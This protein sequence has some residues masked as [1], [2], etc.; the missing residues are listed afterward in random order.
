MSDQE[1]IAF[2]KSIA[3]EPED[4]ASRLVFADFLD[5]QDEE[6]Y[7]E[8]AAFIRAD[9]ELSQIDEA[10]VR[11]PEMLARVRR[12]GMFTSRHRIPWLSSVPNAWVSFHRGL[13]SGVMLSPEDHLKHEREDW[14]RLPIEQVHWVETESPNQWNRD[15]GE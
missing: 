2:Q 15:L 3:S 9:I 6:G 5:E 1:L 12:A 7:S 11:Y 10:D 8:M 14:Q 4:D 13:I